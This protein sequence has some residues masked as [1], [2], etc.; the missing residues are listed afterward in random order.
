MCSLMNAF[1]LMGDMG[2]QG[3]LREFDCGS[4]GRKAFQF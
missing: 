4:F 2:C 1:G 3:A